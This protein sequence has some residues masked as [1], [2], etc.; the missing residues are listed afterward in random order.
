MQTKQRGVSAGLNKNLTNSK[1]AKKLL[2]SL[3]LTALLCF[4]NAGGM[5]ISSKDFKNGDNLKQNQIANA[6]G[7]QGKNMSPELSWGGVPKTAKS[8]A[9]S[10]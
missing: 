1:V 8:L 2:L 4:A 6:Y 9:I 3:S 7:C 10:A 5:T